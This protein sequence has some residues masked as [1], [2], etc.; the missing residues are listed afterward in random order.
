MSDEALIKARFKRM[1]AVNAACFLTAIAAV[2]GAF[3]LG[4]DWLFG[5]FGLAL[6]AG[7]GAQIWFIAAFRRAKEGV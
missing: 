2:V 7:F 4:Q 1:A 5:V 3:A 6:A